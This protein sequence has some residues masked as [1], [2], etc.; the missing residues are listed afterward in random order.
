VAKFPTMTFKS[1]RAS[2]AG[3]GKLKV[4]G[5]LTLRGVTKEVTL[6]VDGPTPEI[7]DPWGNTRVG[8]TATT[9]T[10]RSDFGVSWN[11]NLDTGGVVVGDEVSI[12]LDLE[13][14]KKPEEAKK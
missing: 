11:K 12:T 6:D 3:E 1:K 7:K 2:S 9:K 14:R 8:A 5:D 10:K 4:V 13:L